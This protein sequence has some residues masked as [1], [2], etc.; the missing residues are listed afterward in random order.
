MSRYR[1]A[2]KA[3]IKAKQKRRIQ[4][5]LVF[6]ALIMLP[7]ILSIAGGFVGVTA[8]LSSLPQLKNQGEFQNWQTTKIYAADG[9]LLTNLYY[10]QDRIVVPLSEISTHL[11]NG[12]IAIEDERFYKH[13]GYDPE[14]IGRAFFTNLQSGHVVEGASTITQQYIKNTI[15]SREK[16]FDRKIKEAALAYQLEQKYTKDQILEKYLNTIYFGHSQYGVETAS[17][18]FFG[19]RAKELTLAEAA[20]LAGI[21]KS[22]INYSPY[23]HLDKAKERRDL[24][25]TQMANLKYITEQE[26]K[27]AIATPVQVKPLG[28]DS[29]MAPYF[30]E[31]VKQVLIKKYGENVVF[32]GGLR[33]YTTINLKMQRNAEEAAWSTLNKPNDPA[34]AL[35]AIEPATGYIRA[36][37]GGRD[38]NK[39]KYNL[40]TSHNRQPGSSFKTFVFTAAIENGLSPFQTYESSPARL[41]IPGSEDWKVN[42][43][44][45]GSGGPPM[46][47]REAL[48]K[49]VNTVY[50]RLIM[51]VGASKVADIAKK[52]GIR[53]P[54]N[55]NPAIA[56][57]GFRNG[58]SPLDMASAYAT[59]A[60][61]GRYCKPAAI[62]KV[63]DA[64]GK[65]L[66]EPK[67]KPEQVISKATAYIV[68][69]TLQDVIRHGTGG[70]ARISRPCAG[71]TGTAQ[72]YRDAWFCG[73]TP[74]LSTAVW[75]GYRDELAS[76]Y[77]VHGIRVAGGT[78]P[79]QIWSKF[80]S[81]S[82][83]GTRVYDFGKPKEGITDVLVCAESGLLANKYCYELEHRPF[84]TG[85][86]PKKRCKL[87]ASPSAVDIPPVVGLTEKEA[88]SMLNKVHFK[89]KITYKSY[90]GVAEGIVTEQTPSA[91]NEVKQDSIVDLVVNKKPESQPVE[92]DQNTDQNAGQSIEMIDVTGLSE[93]S[94]REKLNNLDLKVVS[95]TATP[96]LSDPEKQDKVVFQDPEP[97]TILQSGLTVT[98]YVNRQ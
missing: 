48:V 44:V 6:C 81:K 27:Q 75:V 8:I 53:S 89:Y 32:K 71:K 41:K 39:N 62:T 54:I 96:Y 59:L 86:T 51:D 57:G 83:D 65:V 69:D 73:Y 29:T 31:Y 22:P 33:V 47:I 49:S 15:I 70:R 66:Y 67:P 50:A 19:K 12:V 13:K 5:L 3:K 36:M 84:L 38:F 35:A 68:T 60:N 25:L 2:R 95:V 7:I 61:Y 9:T 17:L 14:A 97:D 26:A 11:Q 18:T 88:I 28:K 58:P 79:A 92:T 42:N 40:T 4:I 30:V 56:L 1:K 20:L 80:M 10:E 91:G 98:I 77:N 64:A 21:T 85:K 37:V 55:P 78:F 24:V 45:E 63:T 16:T 93:T 46:T 43:Y 82:L 34:V 94:A 23:L 72:A 74:N 76:M 52:M 87:H 90:T